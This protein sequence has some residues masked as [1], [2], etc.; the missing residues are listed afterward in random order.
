MVFQCG[1]WVVLEWFVPSADIFET[2][3]L[4][5]SVTNGG[6]FS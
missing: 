2:V 6:R 4:D 3:T 1:V 5:S